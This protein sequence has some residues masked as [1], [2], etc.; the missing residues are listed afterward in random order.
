V[1]G[2]ATRV[3]SRLREIQAAGF[4]DLLVTLIAVDD[5]DAEELALISALR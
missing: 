1:S 4:E 2:D 5:V 3:A